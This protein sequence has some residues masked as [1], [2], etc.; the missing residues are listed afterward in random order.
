MK[1][2]QHA[3]EGHATARVLFSLSICAKHASC[4]QVVQAP[5][6]EVLVSEWPARVADA[7]HAGNQ[8]SDPS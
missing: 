1:M 5:K 4:H 2:S 7:L 6:K 3:V 8:I